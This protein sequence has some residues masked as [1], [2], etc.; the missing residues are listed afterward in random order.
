MIDAQNPSLTIGAGLTS[1]IFSP[2]TTL[3][4][5]RLFLPQ[6]LMLMDTQADYRFPLDL[7]PVEGKK[8]LGILIPPIYIPGY[9]PVR[10]PRAGI[11]T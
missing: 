2:G 6:G 8:E 9:H 10:S 5:L 4:P 7:G 1:P 3:L 11:A